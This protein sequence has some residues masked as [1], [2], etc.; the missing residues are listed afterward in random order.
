MTPLKKL[1]VSGLAAFILCGAATAAGAAIAG[2]QKVDGAFTIGDIACRWTAGA[3]TANPPAALTV[4]RSTVNT[5]V[6][7]LTCD[8]GARATLNNSP[9]FTFDDASALAA[10][11]LLDIT[12]RQG[13]ISCRYQAT[14]IQW[15][16]QGDTRTYT[17]RTF[18]ARKVSG[19]FLCPSTTQ[20]DAGDATLTFH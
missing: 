19:G 17:N 5:P 11:P 8:D 18:T 16:R 2:E 4:D 6:G 20:A 9:G 13:F 12:G 15:D 3:T 1:A 14:D 10:T 7:N